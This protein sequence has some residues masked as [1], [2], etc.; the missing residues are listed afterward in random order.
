M[1]DGEKTLFESLVAAALAAL[2]QA[3]IALDD[4]CY[5]RAVVGHIRHG[6]NFVDLNNL[7]QAPGMLMIGGRWDV[8]IEVDKVLLSSSAPE[9]MKARAVLTNLFRPKAKLLILLK[10]GPVEPGKDNTVQ[11]W[12][13]RFI[14]RASTERPWRVVFVQ[15]AGSSGFDPSDPSFPPRCL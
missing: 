9:A 3:P 5:D 10:N 11:E 4:V 2:I 12:G 8:D 15:Q 7:V 13:G 14:P 6:E 1:S